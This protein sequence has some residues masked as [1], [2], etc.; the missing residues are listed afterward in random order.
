M[1]DGYTNS[2]QLL[3]ILS[4]YRPT[5]RADSDLCISSHLIRATDGTALAAVG[6]EPNRSSNRRVN[7]FADALVWYRH[8]FNDGQTLRFVLGN[9]CYIEEAL[10]AL[11]TLCQLLQQHLA[12]QIE[13]DEKLVELSVPDFAAEEDPW[14]SFLLNRDEMSLPDLAVQLTHEVG[15]PSFC[16][17]Y[18]LKAR[19]WSGHVEGLE[20][21][22]IAPD[23]KSGI[24]GF[25][26]RGKHSSAS[27]ARKRFVELNSQV[28]IDF[29]ASNT[30][31]A[32]NAIKALVKDREAGGLARLGVERHLE[33]RILRGAIPVRLHN[34]TDLTMVDEDHAFQLPSRRHPGGVA[35]YLDVLMKSGNAPWAVEV[36]AAEAFDTRLYRHAICQVVLHREFIRHARSFYPWYE[37]HGLDPKQCQAAVVFPKPICLN[38]TAEVGFDDIKWLADL[39]QVEVIA[40]D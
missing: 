20:V 19:H 33:S 13:V 35:S 12:I 36:K 23:G 7:L 27:T 24:L 32:G 8:H 18:S 6:G 14:A 5:C 26:K 15:S 31:E 22:Q 9:Y 1:K 4:R 10:S 3:G 2:K 30:S 28:R 38:K 21:C 11:S 39:F 29:D 17:H 25:V 34:S 40:L 16:W 37:K